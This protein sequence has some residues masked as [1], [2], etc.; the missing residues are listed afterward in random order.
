MFQMNSDSGLSNRRRRTRRGMVLSLAALALPMMVAGAASAETKSFVISYFYDANF[1]DGKTD[2]PNGLNL[3]AIDFYRRDLA[4]AGHSHDEIEAALKDFPGEGG[5]KQ[6]WVPLV[7]H[8]GNGK[9]NVYAHPETMADPGEIEVTGKYSYGFNLDGKGAASPS[10]FEEPDTHEQGVNN[11]LYKVEGCI[12]SY[13]GLPP[14]GR[15]SLPENL[16]DVLRDVM[17]AWLITVNAPG[18]FGK[19]GPVTVTWDRALERITRDASGA[20]AQADMTYQVDPDPRSHNELKGAIKGNVVTVEP[21]DFRMVLDPYLQPEIKF[22]QT[23]MRL[24]IAADGSVRGVIGGYQPW[25]TVYYGFADQGH[26]KE[27]AGSINL[28]ALYYA[29]KREA[30]YDPDPKTGENR[31]ISSAYLIE[32]VPAFVVPASNKTAQ[33]TDTDSNAKAR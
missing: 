3:S 20:V 23:H 10:K 14:P 5:L 13:R 32:A 30:D 16:W 22:A 27:Y 7:A 19:D 8:R 31:Q 25:A 18:G 6:P 33:A 9:D 28:P 11:G 15:P 26:I 4:K 24:N 21:A 29:L 2:C 17:P 1:S 12:R